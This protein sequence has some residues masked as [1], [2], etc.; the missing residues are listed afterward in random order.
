MPNWCS[1]SLTLKHDDPAMITKAAEA[2]KKGNFFDTFIPCPTQ[3]K[4]AVASSGE[5][6]KEQNEKNVAE[7]GYASWYDFCV[8]EWGTK[9]DVESYNEPDIWP[10]GKTLQT[11]FDSAWSPPIEGFRKL[12][13][14]GFTVEALYYEPG[15]GFC[16]DYTT[17]GDESFYDYSSL[18]ADEAEAEIPEHINEMFNISGYMRDFEEENAED[19]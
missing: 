15:M 13:E 14:L 4:E 12:D 17:A 2:L 6:Y 9:W 19:E 8:N 10:D 16:G 3:L 5:E 18:N 11:S 7:T 1:N